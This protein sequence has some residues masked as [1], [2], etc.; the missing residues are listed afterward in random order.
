MRRVLRGP[1]AETGRKQ[2]TSSTSQPRPL[3]L[4]DLD[5]TLV[6]R[7]KAYKRWAENFARGHSLPSE[8]TVAWLIGLD[9][10]G[11]R[12]R[13]E[14][15][16]SIAEHF[17][18]WPDRAQA[19]E[20]FR[21]DLALCVPEIS[22]ECREALSE[23]RRAGWRIAIVTNGVESQQQ[24]KVRVAGLQP[25]VDACVVSEAVGFSKPNPAIFRYAAA[26]SG[27]EL[28]DGWLIGDDPVTDIAGG[29]DVGLA[30]IWVRRGRTWNSP[31]V[32][33][34]HEVDAIEVGLRWLLDRPCK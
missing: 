25:L 10:R 9:D 17:G 34:T 11:Y 12:P 7:T 8:D 14:L 23:L 30:T 32:R 29:A 22:I 31:Q 15:V 13:T 33:P 3:L 1:V 5:D 24:L 4:C 27:A 18:V 20:E 2:R 26:A 16:A 28:T 21:R 19:L 6:D